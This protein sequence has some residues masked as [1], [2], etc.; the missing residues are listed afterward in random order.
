MRTLWIASRSAGLSISLASLLLVAANRRPARSNARGRA[1]VVACCYGPA[2]TA[3]Q[4]GPSERG[5]AVSS[6]GLASG[7]F[8]PASSAAEEIWEAI[9]R[10]A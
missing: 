6:K 2:R 5:D 4:L 9:P 1:I 10:T 3:A 8:E 7:D